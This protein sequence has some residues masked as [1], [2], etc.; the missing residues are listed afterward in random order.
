MHLCPT[1]CFKLVAEIFAKATET[2]TYTYTPLGQQYQVTDASGTTTYSY[3]AFGDETQA[4]TPEGTINYVF[5]PATGNHIET[6]TNDTETFYGYDSQGQLTSVTVKEA[7]GTTLST[8]LTTNYTYDAAG[9]LLSE[10]DPNG[11][12]TAYT[13][14]D[15]NRMLTETVTENGTT[16]LFEQTYMYYDNGLK[17]SDVENDYTSGTL[18]ATIEYDWQ[19]DNLGRLTQEQLKIDAGTA[20][21]T[22]YTDTISY[23]LDGNRVSMSHVAGGTTDSTTYS[24]NGDDQLTSQTDSQ[25][26]TTTYAYDANGSLISATNNGTVVAS[27]TYNVQNEMVGATVNGVT[28]SDVYDDN[29]DRVEETVN[30]TSTYYLYDDNNPTG[31]DQVIESK[32]SPTAAPSMSYILGLDIIG[33]ADSSG[34]VSYFL[35]DGQG[36][37]RALVNSSGVVTAT[38]NYD[39]EGN[40]LGVTYTPSSPPPTVYLYDQQQLDV[41]LGQYQLRARIYNPETGEFDEYDPMTHDPGDVLG[42]NPYIYADDDASNMDDP[43]GMGAITNLLFGTAVHS[44]LARA[45][46]SFTP[47]VSGIGG[48]PG[49]RLP[50]GTAI[51]GT[52]QRFGNRQIR[53]IARFW[54]SPGSLNILRP[55]FVEVNGIPIGGKLGTGDLYELKSLS[56][57][58]AL[59]GPAMAAAIGGALGK[60]MTALNVSVPKV[61]WSLGTTWIPG[62]TE[63]PTFTSPLL[64]PGSELVTWDNYAS[65]A[66]CNIL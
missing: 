18:S 51:V 6:C 29:G 15:E 3:D 56:L 41:A 21:V 12:T 46:E 63:W 13:Y 52:T 44:F 4:V 1:T 65:C 55:D 48:T 25:T 53:S 37:T 2:V 35:T 66:W 10:S 47:V 17:E 23:D 61:S 31:Y 14:D 60:Y 42:A 64:P 24:Y 39:A 8:P 54:G 33:Q 28:S 34:N 30:G 40:L 49:P 20:S 45:F 43:T 11:M 26:G 57:T 38:F 59:N 36:S 50:V 19:Y 16:P 32:S 27:Y 9:N 7:N 62:L 22:P 5:D 58:E